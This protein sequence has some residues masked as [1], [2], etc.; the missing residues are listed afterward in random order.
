MGTPKFIQ[1]NY[2]LEIGIVGIDIFDDPKF[3]IGGYIEHTYHS[4]AKHG[5]AVC[6]QWVELNDTVYCVVVENQEIAEK[7]LDDPFLIFDACNPHLSRPQYLYC[8]NQQGYL[9]SWQR[10]S[11]SREI[12]NQH[13]D[14]K[15]WEGFEEKTNQCAQ[16][17][18]TFAKQM[19]L[20]NEKQRHQDYQSQCTFAAMLETMRLTNEKTQA[21]NELHMLKRE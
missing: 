4:L 19:T 10:S 7:I 21:Q 3:F 14:K 15:R 1:P 6:Q 5:H 18:D 11:S 17:I 13:L 20:M 12:S 9:T 16:A 2:A 8:L